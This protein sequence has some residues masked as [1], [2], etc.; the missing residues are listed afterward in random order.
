MKQ[1]LNEVHN[2]GNSEVEYFR[3][4]GQYGIHPAERYLDRPLLS[5][6]KR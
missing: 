1:N 5:T 4:G 6:N 3:Y 2:G